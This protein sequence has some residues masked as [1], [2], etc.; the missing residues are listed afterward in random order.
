MV[1]TDQLQPGAL[2]HST[3]RMYEIT[4][5]GP[6]WVLLTDELTGKRRQFPTAWAITHLTLLREAPVCPEAP[7]GQQE[8]TTP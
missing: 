3:H 8:G 1:R 2:V 4:A 5:T 6:G 7:A